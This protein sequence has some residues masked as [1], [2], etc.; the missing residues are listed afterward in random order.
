MRDGEHVIYAVQVRITHESPWQQPK[1]KRI[2]CKSAT[3]DKAWVFASFDY[4]GRCWEPHIG[5]GNDWRPKTPK[6]HDELHDVQHMVGQSGYFKLEYGLRALKR[7]RKA[8]DAGRFDT[9][10]YDRTC[11]A[12]RHEFRLVKMTMS[13]KTEPVDLAEIVEAL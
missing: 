8:D 6:S 1:D 2:K 4:F 12:V 9:P 13:Q 11:Q 5:T 10:G 3:D 7:L